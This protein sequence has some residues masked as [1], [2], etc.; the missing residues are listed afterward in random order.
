M[1]KDL[2]PT[3]V[4]ITGGNG[5]VARAAAT[6]CRSIGDSVVAPDK[7]RL[8]ITDPDAIELII[9]E[10][11]PEIVLNCAAY[12][13]VD[14]AETNV[15]QCFAVNS[16]GVENLAVACR[17]FGAKFVTISTDYVFDGSYSGF[18]TQEFT[19]AP[20]G[21]YA[22]SK[23]EGEQ[24]AIGADPDSVIVR[25]GWIF[26]PGGTNF[27]SVIGDLLKHGNEVRAIEDAFGTPTYA[28]DLARRLRE[29]GGSDAKGIFHVT[30]AGDGTSYLGFAQEVARTLGVDEGQI[31]P[32]KNAELNRPAPRPLSSKLSCV[33]SSVEGFAE[34]PHWTD[35]VRRFTGSESRQ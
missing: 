29:L 6:F 19:P 1:K 31:I 23:L 32:V 28:L 12:T 27:L 3:L 11:K 18:Y 34:L 24:R 7:L 22:R 10:I 16:A 8:D 5:M 4:L 20:Q 35:A 33:R 30:N 15:E 9:A 26:G 13:N 14:G 25:T 2:S 17:R 21:V